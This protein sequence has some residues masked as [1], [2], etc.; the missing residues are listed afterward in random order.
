MYTIV[1]YTILILSY[2]LIV[3]I[4]IHTLYMYTNFIWSYTYYYKHIHA[5][6]YTH[7]IY[8]TLITTHIQVDRF[9]VQGRSPNGRYQG[10]PGRHNRDHQK[11]HGHVRYI[12]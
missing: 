3:F 8:Y 4:Y 2:N 9:S 6:L 11:N 10:E 5:H 7:I 1:I 12:L